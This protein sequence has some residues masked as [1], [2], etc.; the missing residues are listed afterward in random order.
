MTHRL[1]T[2]L[3]ADDLD[4]LLQLSKAVATLD[5]ADSDKVASIV[6]QWADTQAIANLLM[7][8][9]F[10]PPDIR[11]TA[12]RKGLQSP[13]T[14]Y[15]VVAA[16]VG[17]QHIADQL[18]GAEQ[19]V[20]IERLIDIIQLSPPPAS[21]RCSV[22]LGKMRCA[23]YADQ[24]V[25]L[26]S[27]PADEVKHNILVAL[28][29]AIGFKHVL[30]LVETAFTERRLTIDGKRFAETQLASASPFLQDGDIDPAQWSRSDLS[31]PL[32]VYIPNL[33]DYRY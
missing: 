17:L 32:L 22:T 31:A 20:I 4:T 29:E 5:Q 9:E 33:K 18:T 28:I 6:Q 26:L 25:I 23:D 30:P 10:I 2:F 16:A 21:G 13:T 3:Q 15:L 27:H 1:D 8:P 11:F 24:I 14:S 7:Y 12:L 19:R